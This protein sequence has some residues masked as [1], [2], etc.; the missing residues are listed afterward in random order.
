MTDEKLERSLKAAVEKTAPDDFGGVLRAC[1]QRK[2]EGFPV[3]Q[4]R[5]RG[6]PAAVAAAVA[7]LALLVG[8]GFGLV[9]YREAN[10]VDAVVAL[11][12]NPSIE[13]R[14]NR[15]E[16]VISAAAL[17]ADAEVVLG[18]M[19]LKGA[20]LDVAVNAL[21][22]SMVRAGYLDDLANSILISVQ[23]DEERSWELEQRLSRTVSTLLSGSGTVQ[24]S[25]LTQTVTE[26]A[27]LQAM[28]ETY[29]ISLGRAQ[30]INSILEKD[31]TKTFDDLAALTVNELN[32][33]AESKQAATKDLTV[34]GAASE[35]AYVGQEKA[36]DIALQH[37]GVARAAAV[38]LHTQMDWEKGALVYSVEFRTD[39][40]EYE[41][42]VNALTGAIVDVEQ[43]TDHDDNDD[44]DYNDH[45]DDDDHDDH[46]DHDGRDGR[47]SG[48]ADRSAY[49][50]TQRAGSAALS[51]AGLSAS[52]V[53]GLKAEL[54]REDGRM[55][56][57]VE[58]HVGQT[59][60]DYEIDALTGA[61]IKSHSEIDD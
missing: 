11:D 15:G 41:Y 25:V 39:G 32:L 29:G 5:K 19:D 24:P 47:E 43:E 53:S 7:V 34:T 23:G 38:G 48:D 10:A 56:Y 44:Y 49:I 59:E 33:L 37:A 36:E 51:H 57:E 46:D 40:V 2:G 35:K 22:G 58:F 20:D 31:P 60:Y 18:D 28:A 55:I 9:R 3:M 52:Q 42:D 6:G 8:G 13:L 12:V 45:D 1:E 27:S 4:R 17:N 26:D 21:I 54:E 61:V 16:R 14:V 50:G 30:L